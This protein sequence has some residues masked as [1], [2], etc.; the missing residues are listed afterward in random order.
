MVSQLTSKAHFSIRDN[1]KCLKSWLFENVEGFVYALWS[2]KDE[3][4]IKESTFK[5]E[6]SHSKRLNTL[7]SSSIQFERKAQKLGFVK[8]YVAWSTPHS[9][10]QY[11]NKF[12]NKTKCLSQN[13]GHIMFKW[14][15]YTTK[16]PK[17]FKLW[18][19]K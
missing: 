13:Y 4:F 10:Q 5:K 19:F 18:S 3:I 11:Q 16:E 7:S 9:K 14:K 2:G 17:R 8:N 12:A 1:L 6:I 15:T